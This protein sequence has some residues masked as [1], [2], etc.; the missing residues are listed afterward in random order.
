MHLCPQCRSPQPLRAD[1]DYFTLL[2]AP[3]RFEQ[4]L[5]ALQ[6]RFYE[7][8]RLLHPD[9]YT[10]A[11]DARLRAYSLQRMSE[12]N[13]AYQTLR[14]R[15]ALLEH[16]LGSSE[17]PHDPDPHVPGAQVR[18]PM[19]LAEEWFE[20]QDEVL[21]NPAGAVQRLQHLREVLNEKSQGFQREFEKFEKLYDSGERERALRE[22][23]RVRQ[24][25]AYIAS[26]RRDMDRIR[27]RLEGSE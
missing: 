10:Q 8:S 5:S 11:Q 19:E 2:S 7:L 27:S 22:L 26:M 23:R 21:E 13:Q 16:L 3:R 15:E 20:L 12:I 6:K 9:R 17:A 25:S 4:D 18:I 14:S 24:E 1:E